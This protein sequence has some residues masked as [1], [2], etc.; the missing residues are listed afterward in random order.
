MSAKKRKGVWGFAREVE[1]LAHLVSW[2]KLANVMH[3]NLITFL[4]GSFYLVVII[5]LLQ[6][7][8]K[9]DF[10]KKKYVFF[11]FILEQFIYD[12]SSQQMLSGFIQT[13]EQMEQVS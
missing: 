3:L 10:T 1:K 13:N 2:P 12:R 4:S 11:R 7:I 9:E 8:V 5:A 6:H